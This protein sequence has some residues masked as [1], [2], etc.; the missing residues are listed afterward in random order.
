MSFKIEQKSGK[1]IYI[2]EATAYWDPVK[3]QARQKRVYLGRKD[4]KTGALIKR[5]EK[6]FKVRAIRD[7]GHTHLLNHYGEVENLPS[8]LQKHFGEDGGDL[9]ALA[10]YLAAEG[11]PF[12]LQGDWAE[13]TWL[14]HGRGQDSQRISELLGRTGRNDTAR[15]RFIHDW[16]SAKKDTSSV[17]FDITSIS[18]YGS[19]LPTL[20]WGYNRN[21]EDLRQ[22]NLAMVVGHPS[23]V[24]LFYRV[25]PGSIPDVSTLARIAR[26]LD[27]YGIRNH[28]MILD[29]GMYSADNLKIMAD[30]GSKY[31]IP[32]PTSTARFQE[33]LTATASRL[34]RPGSVMAF[35]GEPV[36]GVMQ[37]IAD[38]DHAQEAHIF[39]DEARKTLETNN[40]YKR[41]LRAEDLTVQKK[42]SSTEQVHNFL[43]GL[44]L[45]MTRFFEVELVDGCAKLR[46]REKTIARRLNHFGRMILVTNEVGV[47]SEDV[48]ERYRSRDLVE[49]MFETMKD[50][51]DARRLRAHSSEVVDGRLFVHY[52]ALTLVSRLR[53]GMKESKLFKKY[54]YQKLLGEMKK[55][56]YIDVEGLTSGRT[57]LTRKQ[58]EIYSALGVPSPT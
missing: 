42:F 29:R 39:F 51:L 24:P 44:G 36:Y 28:R 38:G 57:E 14:P 58:K 11:R 12:Y 16:I 1:H 46:R 6:V 25:Y 48:L 53:E 3:Q 50:A 47:S 55:L 33:L 5:K 10:L 37:P 21:G 27:S 40:L 45:G 18:S 30:M 17:I 13:H 43:E 49:K 26:D 20:E 19:T 2:Y 22:I 15:E 9:Y 54:S 4:P 32:L 56:K 23:N 34:V 35:H 8:M 31:L 7:Y 41:I 52:L